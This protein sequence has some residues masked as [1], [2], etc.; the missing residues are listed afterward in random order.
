MPRTAKVRF[1]YNETHEL[2]RRHRR[3]RFCEAVWDRCWTLVSHNEQLMTANIG[4]SNRQT[5]RRTLHCFNLRR[6]G[7]CPH[8]ATHVLN[9]QPM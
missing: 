2:T 7:A 8:L 1:G 4:S 5:N 6:K 9:A 3:K